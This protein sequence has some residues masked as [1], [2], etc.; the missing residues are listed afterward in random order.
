MLTIPD[1]TTQINRLVIERELTGLNAI[2]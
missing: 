1:G 2:R